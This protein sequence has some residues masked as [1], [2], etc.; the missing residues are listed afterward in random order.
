[1]A[2]A[3]GSI[4]RKD[5]CVTV[6][7][8]SVAGLT[9]AWKMA[10]NGIRVRLYEAKEG[11][12]FEPRT[13]IVT[14][15]MERL[16]DLDTRNYVLH[17]VYEFELISRSNS[18]RLPLKKPDLV[19]D[20]KR[21]LGALAGAATRAGVDLALGYRLEDVEC[22]PEGSV[23]RFATDHGIDC[24]ESSLVVGADGAWS[25]IAERIGRPSLPKV[26]VLQVRT[27][28]PSGYPAEL[29]RVWFYRPYTRF[30]FW[31][32]PES[33]D[34]GVFGVIHETM[35]EAKEVM[36]RL[37]SQEG[38]EI[39]GDYEEGW[40][41]LPQLGPMVNGAWRNG[42]VILVGDAAG[43][44][45]ASTV[46]GVVTGI[47]GALAAVQT[48][49][50]KGSYT[51]KILAFWEQ[52][53]LHRLLRKVLDGFT[54]GDYDELISSIREKQM[55]I[56]ATHSRDELGEILWRLLFSKPQWYWLALK[57]LLRRAGTNGA[58][59]QRT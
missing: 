46:G 29:V 19:I 1:M 40:V 34:T 11:L 15:A 53:M 21:L 32:I 38:L 42:K 50:E 9:A 52:L 56:L 36:A 24:V 13:L 58:G 7:G 16:L 49:R 37:M 18:I 22:N 39:S 4:G 14:T 35:E 31:L 59:D 25:K 26:A 20:R 5:T 6:V 43:H 44:V 12:S 51:R 54:D 23:L 3:S 28:L 10:C 41:T 2:F 57:A 33:R 8:A 45:K 48:V 27:R 47:K 55:A 30:F 17:K